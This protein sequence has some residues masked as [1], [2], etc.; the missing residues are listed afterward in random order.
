MKKDKS[1]SKIKNAKMVQINFETDNRDKLRRQ[2]TVESRPAM[3]N[4][5][6][7]INISEQSDS[8]RK[9]IQGGRV[10]NT[11]VVSNRLMLSHDGTPGMLYK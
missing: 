7:D 3:S 1:V 2:T 8:P 10:S 9:L 4:R 6:H 5:D 11:R